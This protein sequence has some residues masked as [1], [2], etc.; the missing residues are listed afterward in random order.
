LFYIDK[1][2]KEEIFL[3]E[4]MK[5]ETMAS[6]IQKKISTWETPIPRFFFSFNTLPNLR[7]TQKTSQ[8]TNC[9]SCA[10]QNVSQHNHST[11]YK[12]KLKSTRK[13]LSRLNSSIT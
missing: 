5:K 4:H 11:I 12:N 7:T 13:T 6:C 8:T 9:L 3:K 1:L 2:S 10:M